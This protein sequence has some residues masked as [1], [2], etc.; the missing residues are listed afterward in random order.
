MVRLVK[1]AECDAGMNLGKEER[2]GRKV[3]EAS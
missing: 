2:E 1:Q 3:V